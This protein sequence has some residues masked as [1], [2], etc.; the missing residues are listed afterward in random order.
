MGLG[1]GAL[2]PVYIIPADARAAATHGGAGF[3]QTLTLTL[4]I[5]NAYI[6][7]ADARAAATHEGAG[8]LQT[9]TLTLYIYN[10]Y[11]VPADAR[12]AAHRSRRCG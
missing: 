2:V 1:L 11:I 8:F 4:Y 9:L 12:A 7:P 3:L 6:V 5:Y 10:A